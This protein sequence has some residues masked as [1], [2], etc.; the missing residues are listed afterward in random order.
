MKLTVAVCT[1]NPDRGILVR[2]LDAIV[3]QLGDVP[4][5]EVIVVD[6]NSSPPLADLEYLASYPI[7]LIREPIAGLTAA[8]ESAINNARGELVLFVDDDN[9]LDDGYL[10]TVVKMFG[11]DPH[12]G[13]LGGCIDP[14]YEIR[15]PRWFSEFEPWLAIRHYSQE[16]RIE[17]TAPADVGGGDPFTKYFPVGAGFATTRALALAYQEDCRITKKIEGRLGSVLSSGEDLDLGLFILSCE[18]KLLVTGALRLTHVIGGGRIRVGYLKRLAAGNVTS[19]LAVERKWS[20]RFGHA[21]YPMFSMKLSRLM[22]RAASTAVLGLGSRRYRVKRHIY[23]TL[24]RVR[25]NAALGQRATGAN[26]AAR[27]DVSETG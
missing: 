11:E 22:L 10:A 16:T 17:T 8:R 19:S 25:W 12:L 7:R 21:I 20:A 26:R 6:N 13:L 27:R 9:I 1:Y 15:P 18:K 2:A 3:A 5:T 4:S 23:M 14:E 24:I